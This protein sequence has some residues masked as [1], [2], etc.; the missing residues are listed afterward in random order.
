MATQA[1]IIIEEANQP[2]KVVDNIPRPSPEGRQVLVKC[3]AVGLNP[4]EAL[5]H[6]TGMMVNEWPAILGS[7]GA[8]IVIEVGPD[9]ARLK[10]GDYVYSCAPVGQNRFTPFQDA[11]LAQEDLLF[12]K[13]SNISLED[14]CTIGACLLTSS[15]CLIGG[16][17]L[18]L[19]DDGNTAPEKDEWIVV[20]GGS[21]NVGQFAI[22]L[23]KVCGYKVL[24]SCS[25]SKQSIAVRN[26]ASATFDSRESVDAQVAEIKKI[27]DGNFGKMMDASTYGY[28]VMVKAL[29]T[30]SKTKE[31]Y[32]TSVDSWSPFST[33]SSINEY[34]AD[35]GHICRPNERDGAQITSNISNWIPLLEKQIAAGTLKPLEHHV[36]DGIG[37]EKVI[38]GIQDMEGGKI[39]K[40]IVVRTQ[41]E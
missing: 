34:R 38:Q 4:I 8:G 41:E 10:V 27:T 36:I 24:A 28:K 18:E 23:G 2:H 25:P 17:G 6:H 21:G 19:P 29:E 5:Q 31:K 26:G 37:W 30:A 33:P 7:D 12:K 40:K 22:Q 14:S 35:L 15:L 32:L 13:G 9:V 1:G 3:L 20:L 16:T 39:G 11:Y